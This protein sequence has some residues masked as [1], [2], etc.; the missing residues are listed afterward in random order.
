MPE[1]ALTGSTQASI[2]PQSGGHQL[3]TGEIFKQ[4]MG[5]GLRSDLTGGLVNPS[6]LSKEKTSGSSSSLSL[7][8]VACAI[9][10]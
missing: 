10:Q 2:G 9:D 6:S 3:A 4:R 8:M 1:C 5:R 7:M